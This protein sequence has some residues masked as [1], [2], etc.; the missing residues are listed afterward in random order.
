MH[1]LLLTL[2]G[3]VTSLNT[4]S[5]LRSLPPPSLASHH[6]PCLISFVGR[7][8]PVTLGQKTCPPIHLPSL[9]NRLSCL[10]ILPLQAPRPLDII[11][12]PAVC[13]PPQPDR[14]RALSTTTTTTTLFSTLRTHHRELNSLADFHWHASLISSSSFSSQSVCSQLHTRQVRGPQ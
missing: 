11:T 7:G 9:S 13:F 6:H 12:L 3:A 2:R 1:L 14:R 5:P 8:V 4:A 10:P